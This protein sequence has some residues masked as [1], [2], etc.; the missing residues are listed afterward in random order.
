MSDIEGLNTMVPI[1]AEIK[2]GARLDAIIT[3][4]N[5]MRA[6][7]NI[8]NN[9]V[10]GILAKLDADAGVTDTD[11]AAVWGVGGSDGNAMPADLASAAITELSG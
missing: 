4:I 11:F 5:E 3:L 9:T 7:L 6:D 2:F 1:A 10:D 8:T